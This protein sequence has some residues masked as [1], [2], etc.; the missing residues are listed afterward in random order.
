MGTVTMVK[1]RVFFTEAINHSSVHR[2]LKLVSPTKFQS[3]RLTYRE[4]TSGI[5]LKQ[6]TPIRLGARKEYATRF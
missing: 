5:R 6:I 4:I 2:F 3:V 1:S